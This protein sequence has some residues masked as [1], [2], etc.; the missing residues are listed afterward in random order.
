[1][2]CVL[3]LQVV[4]CCP[5]KVMLLPL[6]GECHC[7]LTTSRTNCFMEHQELSLV[8]PAPSLQQHCPSAHTTSSSRYRSTHRTNTCYFILMKSVSHHLNKAFSSDP[9]RWPRKGCQPTGRTRTLGSFTVPPKPWPGI[10]HRKPRTSPLAN[11]KLR[12]NHW[13]SS[14]T[15]ALPTAS[16]PR[17]AP[18]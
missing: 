15:N 18:V 10:N 6:C 11:H 1:M 17:P 16:P 2:L 8:L 12:A 9:H 13:V 3:F 7:L 14:R 4:C 5:P